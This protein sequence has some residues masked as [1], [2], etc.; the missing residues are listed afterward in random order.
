MRSPSAL[1][2][3]EDLDNVCSEQTLQRRRHHGRDIGRRHGDAHPFGHDVERARALHGRLRVES[4]LPLA[5]EE[6]DAGEWLRRLTNHRL[7]QPLAALLGEL[8]GREPGDEHP[9][10]LATG[11][12]RDD[13]CRHPDRAFAGLDTARRVRASRRRS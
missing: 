12:E 6:P 5:L 4:C 3:R 9:D 10:P 11:R 7:E 8:V 1:V 13:G 2:E